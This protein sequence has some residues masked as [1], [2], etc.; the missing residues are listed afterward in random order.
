[1]V[2]KNVK[3]ELNLAGLNE[4]MKSPGIQAHLSQCG[5]AVANAAGKGYSE[6][7]HLANWLGISNVYTV[8]REAQAE[9]AEDNT[10]VK[11]LSKVGLKMSK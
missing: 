4:L 3:V 5:R 2:A 11:A 8:T 7:T 9:N 10:L 1:M 6:R